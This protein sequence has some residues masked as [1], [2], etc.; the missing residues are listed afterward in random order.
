[1]RLNHNRD[2]FSHG[3]VIYATCFFLTYKTLFQLSYVEEYSWCWKIGCG[4][5]V[6]HAFGLIWCAFACLFRFW[7]RHLSSFVCATSLVVVLQLL[8]PDPLRLHF[9]L[10][11]YGY[12]A[13]IA[14]AL[15][16]SNGRVSIVLYRHTVFIPSMPGSYYCTT[17]IVYDDSNDIGLIAQAEGVRA[18]ISKIGGHF[19][20]R[21]PACG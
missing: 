12:R 10:H 7:W 2:F 17:E 9:W 13:R 19:Y 1:M 18:A 20:F 4:L 14:T 6:V 5:I 21:Y 8:S 3:V 11:E 16:S 15:P